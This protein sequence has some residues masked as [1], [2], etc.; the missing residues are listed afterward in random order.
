MNCFTIVF[1]DKRKSP[2]NLVAQDSVTRQL[3]VGSLKQLIEAVNS[4][5]NKMEM[6]KCMTKMFKTFS[7]R[8]HMS[9]DQATQLVKKLDIDMTPEKLWP[10][11]RY[12]SA[13]ARGGDPRLPS[14]RRTSS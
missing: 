5:G 7:R 12:F 8:G 10:I 2:V 3:W 6:E 4:Q 1:K 11:F 14:F 13:D 9:F